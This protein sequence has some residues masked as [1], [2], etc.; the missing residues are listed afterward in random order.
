MDAPGRA[1]STLIWPAIDADELDDEELDEE[2]DEDELDDE[3]LDVVPPPL[4]PPPPPP[5]PQATKI[6]QADPASSTGSR[7]WN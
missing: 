2:L 1:V 7:R 3:L 4:K 5:P 6:R